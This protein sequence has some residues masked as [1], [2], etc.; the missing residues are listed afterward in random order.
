MVKLHFLFLHLIIVNVFFWPIQPTQEDSQKKWDYDVGKISDS[1]L[2]RMASWNLRPESHFLRHLKR[3]A[4]LNLQWS[5]FWKCRS[6]FSEIARL[7]N[8]WLPGLV[9]LN[10]LYAYIRVFSTG[11]Y[12]VQRPQNIYF[13]HL[14]RVLSSSRQ[15]QAP[16]LN[17]YKTDHIHS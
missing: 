14:L 1:H 10:P 17:S 5:H 6:T 2:M 7:R 3:L 16:I 13:R 15:C 11:L 8:L 12:C 9:H 4:T